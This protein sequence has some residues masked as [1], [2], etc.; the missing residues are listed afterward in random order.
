VADERITVKLSFT[1]VKANGHIGFGTH[2]N[3]NLVGLKNPDATEIT[4]L[5]AD[6]TWEM[7]LVSRLGASKQPTRIQFVSVMAGM[8]R[9]PKLIGKYW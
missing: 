2:R 9:Q 4:E 5:V 8:R 3:P 7:I 6:T 1:K